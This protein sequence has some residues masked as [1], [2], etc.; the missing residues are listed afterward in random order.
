MTEERLVGVITVKNDARWI[1]PCLREASKLCDQILILNMGSTD[2]TLEICRLFPKADIRSKPGPEKHVNV[3]RE[4]LQWALEE[5]ADWVLILEGS[6]VLEEGAAISIRHH[7]ARTDTR[8]P[9]HSFFYLRLLYFWNDPEFYRCEDIVLSNHWVPRLFRIQALSKETLPRKLH[10]YGQKMNVCIKNFRWLYPETRHPRR[11]NDDYYNT[12]MNEE[13]LALV[14]WIDRTPEQLNTIVVKPVM[15]PAYIPMIMKKVPVQA[16][17]ILEVDCQSGVGVRLKL[18]NPKRE[19]IGLETDTLHAAAAFGRL[20]HVFIADIEK[21]NVPLQAGYF[22]CILVAN[23]F[24]YFQDP[25]KILLYLKKFLRPSGCIIFTVPNLKNYIF[26][27]QLLNKGKGFYQNTNAFEHTP[28]SYFTKIDL[29][30]ILR[31]SNLIPKTIQNI[32]DPAV[33]R[34][35]STLELGKVTLKELNLAEIQE[36]E[37]KAYLVMAHLRMKGK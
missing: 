8:D 23:K 10:G 3:H 31:D 27:K 7:M 34:L 13:G 29:Q 16:R 30:R 24:Q 21:T 37:T 22:D 5:Q 36:L 15:D 12:L 11:D 9:V 32:R 18:E 19:V 26:M 4:F 2:R 20:D 33:P 25:V 28:F 6:E 17:K 14:K 35:S 1:Y